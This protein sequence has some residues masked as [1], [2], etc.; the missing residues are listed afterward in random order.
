MSGPSENV[1]SEELK[2]RVAALEGWTL[3]HGGARIRRDWKLRDFNEAI[4]FIQA[5]AEVA[6]QAQHHPD[7]HLEGYRR[8]WIEIFTHA[9][10]GITESD[11]RLAARIDEIRPGG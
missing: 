3:T 11:L 2:R 7:L 10:G 9:T 4:A 6:E 5:V 8:V 1:I